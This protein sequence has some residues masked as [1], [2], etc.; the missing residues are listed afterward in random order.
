MAKNK[1]WTLVNSNPNAK[2]IGCKWV[3]KTKRDDAGRI[4]RSK[5]R[6][7]TKGFIQR[8]G[9]DYNYMFSPVSSKDSMRI[10]MALTSYFDLE[11]HQ[12]D[13]KIAFLNGDLEEDIYMVQPPRFAENGNE[14]MVCKL[15]KSIYGLKLESRQ[16]F[17][18]FYQVLTAHAFVENKMDDCI[19]LKHKGSKFIFLV[20]YV[21]TKSEG[22]WNNI[23]PTLN[24]Q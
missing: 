12:M 3:H 13:V 9:I 22:S 16:W 8:E 23:N 20:L 6:L 2:P 1:V 17:L 24:L 15:N 19:Y 18:K 4:E 10:I 21:D 5:A 14:N 7:V 11:L